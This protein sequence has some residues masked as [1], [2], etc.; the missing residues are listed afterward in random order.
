MTN[1]NLTNDEKSNL[2]KLNFF[3][4]EKVFVHLKLKRTDNSGKHIFFNGKLK[5]K[6]TD[7]LFLLE[8]RVLGD[9]EVSIFEIKDE[10]GVNKMEVKEK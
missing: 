1:E 6:L 5:R 3:Y 10:G 4:S 8:E 9:T 2:D 7:T